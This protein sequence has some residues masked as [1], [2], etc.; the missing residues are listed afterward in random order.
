MGGVPAGEDDEWGSAGEGAGCQ[1]C[2]AVAGVGARVE[3]GGE[4][5]GGA[6]DAGVVDLGAGV[7]GGCGC[8]G[9]GCVN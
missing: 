8:C 4:E 1:G 3:A 7:V 5:G 2:E 9:G 6:G